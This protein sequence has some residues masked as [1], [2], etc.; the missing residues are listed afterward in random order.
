LHALPDGILRA[1]GL[2]RFTEA[3]TE[4]QLFQYVDRYDS[5]HAVPLKEAPTLEAP[6]LILIGP[7][8]SSAGVA[9]QVAALN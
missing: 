5:L 6:L 2:V 8:A 4:V 1:K 7:A 9:E 3:P